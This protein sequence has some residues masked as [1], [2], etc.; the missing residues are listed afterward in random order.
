MQ[1]APYNVLCEVL[2]AARWAN[3]NVQCQG[4]SDGAG[5]TVVWGADRNSEDEPG[6]TASAAMRGGFNIPYNLAI[7]MDTT[8]SMASTVKGNPNLHDVADQLRGCRALRQCWQNMIPCSGGATCTE[9]ACLTWTTWHC[10]CSPRSARNTVQ[11]TISRIT[12]PLVGRGS[13]VK[14][15][16]YNFINVT[17]GTKQNL[18]METTGTDA[19]VYEIIPFNDVYTKRR[20]RKLCWRRRPW[21][22]QLVIADPAAQACGARRAGN[23][24]RAS[25]LRRAGGAF[26]GASGP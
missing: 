10:S 18:N 16:P 2:R 11:T 22:R 23:L 6:A 5:A 21:P 14:S 15:V 3:R 9:Q 25:D 1:N 26:T 24:L 13:S 8:A 12:A 17:P 7:I 20:G 4:D 19:G